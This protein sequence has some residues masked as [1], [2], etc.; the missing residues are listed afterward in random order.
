MKFTEYIST[1]QVFTTSDLM[2]AMDSPSAAE[3]QLRLAI[4]AGKVERARR[5]LLVSNHG[6]FQDAPVDPSAV[7]AVLDASAVASYH[8]ALEAYGV[9]H[10][11][12][13]AFQFRSDAVRSGF[14]FRGIRYEPVGPVGDAQW[15][16]ARF[17]G[18]RARVATREQTVVDCMD[19][20]SRSGGVEEAVR[21]LTALAYI[22][23]ETLVTLA[24]RRSSATASRVGW[25]LGQKGEDWAVTGD[26][27]ARLESRLGTGPY[28]LGRPRQGETSWS[29][30]WRLLLPADEEEVAT[31]ITRS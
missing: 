3:E 23:V 26:Q 21:S 7:V 6:R 12:G 19:C 8:S 31:W 17:G 9:A 24:E 4:R 29:A 14:A 11:V 15:R 20:P 22:G 27:L 10:N 13:F 18:V 5:G 1:H 28:R 25:L 2:A 16:V 30:R